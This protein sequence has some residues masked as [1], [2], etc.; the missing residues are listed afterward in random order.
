MVSFETMFSRDNFKNTMQRYCRDLGWEIAGANENIAMVELSD[1]RRTQMLSLIR[2]KRGLR[3]SVPSLASFATA[4]EI[5]P[6]LS[7]LV[8]RRNWDLE[9]GFWGIQEIGGSVFSCIHYAEW[10]LIS[11]DY[12]RNIARALINECEDFEESLKIS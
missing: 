11:A 8:L 7:T 5:P 6:Y 4:G 12:M 10:Q 1:T 2:L 9:T 3:F